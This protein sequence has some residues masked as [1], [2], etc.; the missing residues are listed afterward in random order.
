MVWATEN[1]YLVLAKQCEENEEKMP[2]RAKLSECCARIPQKKQERKRDE[3]PNLLE[4]IH[5]MKLPFDKAN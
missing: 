4:R 1:E 3:K 5:K 2:K